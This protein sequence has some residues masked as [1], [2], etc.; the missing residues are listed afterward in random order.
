MAFVDPYLNLQ[1]SS[2]TGPGPSTA[3]HASKCHAVGLYCITSTAPSRSMTSVPSTA[4]TPIP[5]MAITAHSII[6]CSPDCKGK[7]KAH[8]DEEEIGIDLADV[9]L[10]GDDDDNTEGEPKVDVEVDSMSDLLAAE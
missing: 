1:L 2:A 7:R 6:I 4:S 8:D 10:P 5:P 3:S 9:P